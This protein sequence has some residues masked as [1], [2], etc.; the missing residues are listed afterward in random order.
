VNTGAICRAR[1]FK[2]LR[3]A[4]IRLQVEWPA[5]P[6][7]NGAFGVLQA[8]EVPDSKAPRQISLW[9]KESI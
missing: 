1:T 7:T 5:G 3:L 6:T 2:G 8:C 4:G 9:P